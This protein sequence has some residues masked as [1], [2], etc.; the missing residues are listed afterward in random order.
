MAM[1]KPGSYSSKIRKAGALLPDTKLLL[2]HWNLSDEVEANL[3]RILHENLFGK[4]SRSR[5]AE[6][7]TIFKQRYLR[8]AD[9]LKALVTLVQHEVSPTKLDP[10][11]YFLTVQADPLLY[12]VVTEVLVPL[13]AQGHPEVPVKEIED[14]LHQQIAAGKTEG[15]WSAETINRAAQGI[16]S[17]LRD[18]H[19]LEGQ[20]KKRLASLYLPP[21]SFAFIAFLLSRTQ[22][23]GD[24]LLHDPA[25]QLF[26][27]A[28]QAVEQ[29]FFEAHQEQLLEYH[30]AGRVIRIE[31]PTAT[32][33]EY[34]HALARRA[35]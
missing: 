2:A 10:I 13:S 5:V 28:D 6:I 27:L 22:R 33:E 32:L 16:L 11:L 9:I 8:D 15:I 21:E 1:T 12:A 35:Y 34:A 19:I 18:F 23:S 7:L 17:T 4:A 29:Y 24:R 30:A 25:W 26:F 14:W 20:V 31:F 3:R